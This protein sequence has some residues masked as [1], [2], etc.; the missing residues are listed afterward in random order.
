MHRSRRTVL[1]KASLILGALIA[2]DPAVHAE[3]KL[4]RGAYLVEAVGACGNC[5][6]PRDANGNLSGPPL[7]GGLALHTPAF[8][9]YAPNIT[10][11]LKTGIGSWSEN[12]IVNALRNGVTPHGHVIRPPMP[13]P[14]Y[15]S[16]SDGDAHAIAAYLK[17]L[18]PTEHERSESTYRVPVPAGYGS[19]VTSVPEPDHGDLVAYGAYLGKVG[20]CM[21]CH[22]PMGAGGKR[23]P[24]R[25]GAGGFH[26]DLTWG[27]GVSANITPDRETG[28]GAWTD[29]QIV[30]V[31]AQGVDKGGA[32]LSPVMPWP[33]LQSMKPED[34]RAIVAWL[35][36][37]KP[38]RNTVAP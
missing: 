12:D 26:L 29:D 8:D 10:S 13:I 31:L 2:I 28:I 18:P 6:S 23:D 24:D 34:M 37:L 9:A 3:T 33:Y 5:H 27:E 15:R 35:R 11:D 25:V 30:A 36:T 16:L 7:S 21:E 32:P 22:T 1:A 4:D 14:L 20:H 19:P 17:S 38:V